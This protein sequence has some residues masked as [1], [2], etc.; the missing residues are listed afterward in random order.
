[1]EEERFKEGRERDHRVKAED[2][3]NGR[4]LWITW[5]NTLT[6]ENKNGGPSFPGGSVIE[7]LPANAGDRGSVLVQ[8][9]PTCCGA[10]KP[11]WYNY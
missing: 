9:D 7:N 5:A 10:T 1:M 8:E 3:R 11:L 2:S 6:V 4:T